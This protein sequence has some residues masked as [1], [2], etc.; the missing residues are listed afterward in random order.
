ME[1]N[2]AIGDTGFVVAL[3]NK[4]DTK[5]QE[6]VAVYLKQQQILLP[7]PVLTEVAY[8]IGRQADITTLINFLQGLSKSR[9]FLIALTED[10]VMRVAEILDSY[11]DSRIDFV[12]ATVMAV[13][14]RF[15]S[16][17]IL[18]L[19]RRDFSIFRPRHCRY[20]EILP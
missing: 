17:K 12:D 7:Q 16:T 13:A 3:L 20:F 5:H 18:T 2:T 11:K 10:D 9:F 4:A 19:D 6:V 1:R 14:E 8:L 15:K